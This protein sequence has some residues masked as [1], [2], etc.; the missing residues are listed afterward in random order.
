MIYIGS[1]KAHKKSIRNKIEQV[2][3]F[4]VQMTCVITSLFTEFVPDLNM[5]F[6]LGWY[7]IAAVLFI[8]FFN[9]YFVFEQI[10]YTVK[11]YV[12]K[13]VNLI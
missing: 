4:F 3:E 7:M 12:L 2:N 6:L 5:Q 13:V 8:L 10:F 1:A 11:S 9:L